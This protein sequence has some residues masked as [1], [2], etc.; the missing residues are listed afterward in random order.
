MEVIDYVIKYGAVPIL[1]I[2]SYQLWLKVEKQDKKIEV[3]NDAH[4]NDIRSS[5]EESKSIQQNTLN[6]IND[7]T[8]KLGEAVDY[9]K[10]ITSDDKR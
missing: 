1:C 6:T 9:I 2:I 4:K 3:I 10:I 8:V 7:F 5:G